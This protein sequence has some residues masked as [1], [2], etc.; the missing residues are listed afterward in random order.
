MPH[1]FVAGNNLSNVILFLWATAYTSH[2]SSL[3]YGSGSGIYGYSLNDC[4]PSE[5]WSTNI[6]DNRECWET[7]NWLATNL[8]A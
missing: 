8:R 7:I 4:H 5:H 2:V 1:F 3:Q 6:M